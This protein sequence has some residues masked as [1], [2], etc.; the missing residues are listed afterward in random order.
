MQIAC[1]LELRFARN[2]SQ[3]KIVESSRQELTALVSGS[4]LGILKGLANDP[5]PPTRIVIGSGGF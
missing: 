1:S 2:I 5:V 4:C 3:I